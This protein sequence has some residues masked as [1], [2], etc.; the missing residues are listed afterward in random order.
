MYHALS[1]LVSDAAED[2]APSPWF[3]IGLLSACLVSVSGIQRRQM[4]FGMSC[5]S[6]S[7][8]WAGKMANALK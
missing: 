1:S 4:K 5:K 7:T 8:I 2:A 3:T 6:S